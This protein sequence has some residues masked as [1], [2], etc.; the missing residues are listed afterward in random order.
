MKN[1]SIYRAHK[2]ML[3][4]MLPNLGH[5]KKYPCFRF[6]GV[7]NSMRWVGKSFLLDCQEF[8]EASIILDC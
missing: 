7:K 5:P 1:L 3:T 4:P 6:H 8:H 2:K